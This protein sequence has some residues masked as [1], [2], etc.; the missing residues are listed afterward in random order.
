MGR[1]RRGG[2]AFSMI[3]SDTSQTRVSKL[4]SD[5]IHDATSSKRAGDPVWRSGP[6]ADDLNVRQLRPRNYSISWNDEV[7]WNG[8]KK[9]SRDVRR[10]ASPT[11]SDSRGHLRH[12]VGRQ[13]P[14]LLAWTI[15]SARRFRLPTPRGDTS[16]AALAVIQCAL[17]SVRSPARGSLHF[18]PV[19]RYLTICAKRGY[20]RSS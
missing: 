20:P 2:P 12:L 13:R 19:S 18:E 3:C 4:L 6:L 7:L 14:S 10:R 1:N 11:L 15:L 8:M 17:R 9:A 5:R 16:V